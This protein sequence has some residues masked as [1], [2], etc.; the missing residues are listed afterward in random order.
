MPTPRD[1]LAVSSLDGTLHAFGGRINGDYSQ[2]LDSNETYDPSKNSWNKNKPIPI[3]RSGITS[4]PLNGKIFVF[5]GESKQGTFNQNHAFNPQKN[6]W[7]TMHPMLKAVHGLGSAV[8]GKQI[9]LLNGETK[10]GL[11]GSRLHQVF[12]LEKI[13]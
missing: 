7:E 8:V 5:G 11:G 9:H 13:N 2:N 10:P 12:S 4:Q 3:S 6:S 1:H